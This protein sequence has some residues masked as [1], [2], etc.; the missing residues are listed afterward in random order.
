MADGRQAWVGPYVQGGV[1]LAL[2]LV[3]CQYTEVGMSRG[4]LPM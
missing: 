3:W 2:A 1:Q 4:T